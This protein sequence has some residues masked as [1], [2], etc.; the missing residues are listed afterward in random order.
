MASTTTDVVPPLKELSRV[1]PTVTSYMRL[2]GTANGAATR[3][4]TPLSDIARLLPSALIRAEDP[5]FFDHHGVDWRAI[6]RVL[7]GALRTG[8]IAGGASTLAQQLARNL[9][10]TPTRSVVRKLREVILAHRLYRTLSKARILELYLNLVEWGPGVWG[11]AGASDYYFAKAP[12]DLDLFE[13]T[14]LVTLLAAPRSG[15]SPRLATRS[16]RMQLLLG[17]QLLLSGQASAEACARCSARVRELHRLIADGVPLRAALHHSASV[18]ADADARFLA[19]VIADLHLELI[20]PDEMLTSRCAE[21][22]QQKAAYEQL[23]TRFGGDSMRDLFA[24]GS[25]Q[26]LMNHPAAPPTRANPDAS[27]ESLPVRG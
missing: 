12:R 27:Q 22:H 25:Y 11:V 15:L 17:H 8:R 9:Y 16:R 10:L 23:R 18:N 6:R 26:A 7:R 14:F 24:T 20:R 2:F 19:E 21:R 1:N 5:R 13:A 3:I 4:W